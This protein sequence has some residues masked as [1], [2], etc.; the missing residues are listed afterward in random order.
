MTSNAAGRKTDMVPFEE[1]TE[2]GMRV[3]AGRQ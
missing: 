3:Y 1:A 2:Q